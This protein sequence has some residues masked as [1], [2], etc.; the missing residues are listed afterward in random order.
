[1]TLQK[2]CT[3]NGGVSTVFDYIVQN[4]GART[5]DIGPVLNILQKTLDRLHKKLNAE[6]KVVV[7]GAPKTAGYFVRRADN[8]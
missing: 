1:V 4:P 5:S 7:K 2:N 6:Q 3:I 8:P